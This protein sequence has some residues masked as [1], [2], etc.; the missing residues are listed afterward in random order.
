MSS[1][2]L[3]ILRI[4]KK[5]AMHLVLQLRAKTIQLHGSSESERDED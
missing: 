1:S 5:E 2:R 3:M 4:H